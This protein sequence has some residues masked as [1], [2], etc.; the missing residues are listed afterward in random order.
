MT[1][2]TN[3]RKPSK[4]NKTRRKTSAALSR[5]FDQAATQ[6]Q[7]SELVHLTA[8]DEELARGLHTILPGALKAA[9]ATKSDTRL[10]RLIVRYASARNRALAMIQRNRQA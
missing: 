4:M 8:L 10:L 7:L 2:E 6:T 1:Q 5:E 3:D 9:A